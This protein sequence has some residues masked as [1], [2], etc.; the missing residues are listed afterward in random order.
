MFGANSSATVDGGPLQLRAVD[1][2]VDDN[3]PT[4]DTLKVTLTKGFEISELRE[5]NGMV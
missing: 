3:D 2:N 1:W 5:S 4:L